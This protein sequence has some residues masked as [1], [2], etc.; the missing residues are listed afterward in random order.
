M[1]DVGLK[2]IEILRR[3]MKVPVETIALETPLST[4]SIESIDLAMIVFDIEDTF[5]IEL[6]YN[7]NED[8]D[9]L[10]TVGAVVDRVRSLTAAKADA[11]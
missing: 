10:A 4:L 6:P 9:T 5:G 11:A 8:V 1:D 3:H 2:I 7:A